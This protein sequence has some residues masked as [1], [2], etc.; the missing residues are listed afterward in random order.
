MRM[1]R[2]LTKVRDTLQRFTEWTIEKIRR[3]ENGRATP[4]RH[5][6]LPP[7]QRSHTVAYTCASQPFRRRNLH[8]QHHEASQ[9]DS[10]EWTAILYNTSG[11][12]LCPRIPSST[13]DPG[14]SRPFHPDWGALV[15]KVFYRSLPSVPKS[16]RG[17]V[18]PWPCAQWGM[19]IVGPLPAAPAQKKFL[20]VSTDYFSKW[21][22]A[23]AYASIKDKDHR[24]PEFCSELN[25]GIH[26]P[27][28][29][30]LKVT[31]SRGHKQ[32]SNHCLKE[33]ARASKE[34]WVEELPGVLW[35]YRTTPGRPTGNTPFVL[36][37]GM[38]AI[39]PTEIGLP[40]IRTE[41][42]DR[43]MQM[44]IR[45]KLG[46]GRRSKGNCIHPDG[47]LSTKGIRSLQSQTTIAEEV[48]FIYLLLIPPSRVASPPPSKGPS[49]LPPHAGGRPQIP[50]GSLPQQAYPESL[51]VLSSSGI[52]WLRPAPVSSA[53]PLHY[54][55]AKRRRPSYNQWSVAGQKTGHVVGPCR[56]DRSPTVE[57]HT[58]KK[59]KVTNHATNTSVSREKIK[60]ANYTISTASNIFA[61]GIATSEP[62][63][64]RF[65][66]SSNSA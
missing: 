40:T 32:N 58:N 36:A 14:A 17:P 60:K 3:T 41:A 47:R 64:I 53:A 56:E 44:Q 49:R 26:T 5:S 2:Y 66:F 63:G 48:H 55:C 30:I 18:C 42:E 13:Q 57:K 12:A 38:D 51:V 16:F 43:T 27:H 50:S 59:N 46:L 11:Q 35:A 9:P 24:I 28:R 15:Q 19:D 4:G 61:E 21:V 39:I 54:F 1:A 31:A 45:K 6:C 23:E 34:K 8:L 22:E 10:Q 33:K 62:G 37:Y 20:L 29:V 65:N 52:N 25:I 7:H